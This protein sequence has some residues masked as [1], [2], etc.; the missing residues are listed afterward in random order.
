MCVRLLLWII[1]RYELLEM[2]L[3][4]M[5]EVCCGGGVVGLKWIIGV[6]YIKR[7]IISV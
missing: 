1:S 5:G 7:Y 4:V 3:F 6:G 2:L